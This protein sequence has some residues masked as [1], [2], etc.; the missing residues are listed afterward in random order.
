MKVNGLAG[1][2]GASKTP[3]PT[4]RHSHCKTNSWRLRGVYS[5]E[6]F[7]WRGFL[8]SLEDWPNATA[9]KN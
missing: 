5:Q 2:S 9:S 1:S 7:K 3:P 6:Q 4:R 8:Q